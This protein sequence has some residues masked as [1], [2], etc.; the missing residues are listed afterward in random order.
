MLRLKLLGLSIAITSTV[1]PFGLNAP[2]HAGGTNCWVPTFKHKL[3]RMLVSSRCDQPIFHLTKGEVSRN[4][5]SSPDGRIVGKMYEVGEYNQFESSLIA[6]YDDGKTYWAL[7]EIFSEN[8]PAQR[9]KGW[10]EV[11]NTEAIVQYDRPGSNRP[12]AEKIKVL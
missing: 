12:L 7:G 6:T 10:V 9:F 11:G 5:R 3:D 4:V 1:V 2:A 8:N